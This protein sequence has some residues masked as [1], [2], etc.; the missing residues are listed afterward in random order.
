M[1]PVNIRPA[2]QNDLE[3]LVE[4]NRAMAQETEGL[5]LD[6][7]R[8]RAGVQ[9][10]LQD[11]QRGRYWVA[12]DDAGSV[13]GQLLVTREWSDWRNAWMWWIQSVYVWPPHRRRGVYRRLYEHV[14]RAAQQEGVAGLR[15]YVEVENHRAQAVYRQLGMDGERYRL[16][17]VML[18]GR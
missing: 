18:A 17:E 5:D 2:H 4:G 11:P 3:P 6:E 9:A 12:V 13:L 14:G 16:Y 7:T 10:A 8:L 15:L 1:A